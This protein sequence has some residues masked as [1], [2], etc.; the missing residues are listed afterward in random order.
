M[1]ILS[2]TVSFTVAVS[3]LP[4]VSDTF[5]LTSANNDIK[6]ISTCSFSTMFFNV[7]HIVRITSI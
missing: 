5:L 7:Q 1:I 3:S 2:F 4:H 6:P